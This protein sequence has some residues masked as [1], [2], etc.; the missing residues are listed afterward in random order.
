MKVKDAV[1]WLNNRGHDFEHNDILKTGSV[2][3]FLF[4]KEKEET[5]VDLYDLT[6]MYAE[7]IEGF[8]F[9]TF[10]WNKDYRRKCIT[11]EI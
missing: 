5:E 2:G 9:E 4:I 10:K 1:Q 3:K 11:G 8:P 7:C 6:D